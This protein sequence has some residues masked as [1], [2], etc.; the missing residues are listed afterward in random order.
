[1]QRAWRNHSAGVHVRRA[2]LRGAL[3]RRWQAMQRQTRLHRSVLV[4]G[5]RSRAAYGRWKLPANQRS[6]RLQDAYPRR[7][8]RADGLRGLSVTCT[9]QCTSLELE[10]LRLRKDY[11]NRRLALPRRAVPDDRA[12]RPQQQQDNDARQHLREA[13]RYFQHTPAVPTGT[14]RSKQVRQPPGHGARTNY[15]LISAYNVRGRILPSPEA[16]PLVWREG[17]YSSLNCDE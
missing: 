10:L 4:R 7:T 9:L 14:K 8:R 5:L 17:P 15:K 12:F 3:S 13:S 11:V 2:N 6:V 1:V 16:G